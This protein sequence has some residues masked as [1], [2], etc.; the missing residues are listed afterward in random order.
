MKS[1]A[2]QDDKYCVERGDEYMESPEE[3]RGFFISPCYGLNV[4]VLQKFIYE[5]LMPNVMV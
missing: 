5:V 3:A 1:N 2:I 4:C